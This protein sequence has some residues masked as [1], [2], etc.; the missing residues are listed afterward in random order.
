MGGTALRKN[1]KGGVRRWEGNYENKAGKASRC[2]RRN[3]C[4][5]R[6][7]SQRSYAPTSYELSQRRYIRHDIEECPRNPA[8]AI[9]HFRGAKLS[10][11]LVTCFRTN[12]KNTEKIKE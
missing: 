11:I 8:R 6:V 5:W 12:W 7:H 2:R 1:G 9:K 3:L 4:K 10:E